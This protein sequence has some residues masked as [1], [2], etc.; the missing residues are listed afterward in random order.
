MPDSIGQITSRTRSQKG[1]TL[2][3]V[4]R[5]LHIKER[6]LTAIEED[7]FEDLPSAV[8]GR[9][10][11]HLY[12]DYLGL[13]AGELELLLF[14]PSTA[15]ETI[16]PVEN[17]EIQGVTNEPVESD[18]IEKSGEIA[19]PSPPQPDVKRTSVQIYKAIGEEL[20]K[21]RSR[22]SLSVANIE[23]ITHIPFHYLQALE[24]GKFDE[25]P[26][27][28]Q[29]RGML[30]N[31][32]EFLNL[33]TDRVLL[34]YAE[35]LQ[36]KREE[37]QALVEKKG[38][39]RTFHLPKPGG[40]RRQGLAPARSI[41][42]LDIFI[43]ILL[44]VITFGSLIWG[45]SAIVSYQVDPKSTKTAQAAYD[46]LSRTATADAVLLTASTTETTGTVTV[47]TE[48]V[49]AAPVNEGPTATLAAPTSSGFPIQVFVV[50]LQRAY[51]QII[52]DGKVAFNGRVLPGNPYLFSGNKRIELISG[53]ASALQVIY[54]QTDLGTLGA[55][56]EVVHLIFTLTEY[57][58]PTLT[59]S[60]TPSAT[61]KPSKTPK[62]SNTYPPT[63]TP[64]PSSTPK[65]T[66]TSTPTGTPTQ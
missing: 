13:P 7:R 36:H 6:Y 19:E 11:I 10:F 63:R 48:T 62:P 21:Q 38:N 23:E 47:A 60:I 54:N 24:A 16:I 1:I 27:P 32:A 31:Y 59:P 66:R 40:M 5:A 49:T 29:G 46:A 50:A 51:L 37:A 28:V 18:T 45:A 65:P 56:G 15:A 9:G 44:A 34:K 39:K 3:Q 30:S 25:L 4:Y 17:H 53:N 57:G 14:P 55:S 41:F 33:D 61:L 43:V 20:Q 64:R 8:Q 42:S 26:S 58:T 2:L 12:W 22:L 35:A 52:V